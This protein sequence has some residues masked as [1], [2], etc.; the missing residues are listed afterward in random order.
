MDLQLITETNMVNRC[1][2]ERHKDYL[3]P[4]CGYQTKKCGEMNGHALTQHPDVQLLSWHF[5]QQK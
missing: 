1:Y 2:R 4:V 5:Y 3:C